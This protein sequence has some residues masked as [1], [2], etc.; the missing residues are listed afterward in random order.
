MGSDSTRNRP[1][2]RNSFQVSVG[3]S[4]VLDYGGLV[5]R[6]L[7]IDMAPVLTLP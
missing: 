5:A 1:F 2:P 6:L 7:G 4:I 3:F